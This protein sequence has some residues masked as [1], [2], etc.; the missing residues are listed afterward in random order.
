MGAG[1]IGLVSM[2]AL[3]A[4]GVSEVYVVDVMDK[5]LEKAME[6]GATGVI[7]G[8]KEDV[9]AKVKELTGGRGTDVVIETAGAEVTSS[10]LLYTS[11]QP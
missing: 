7:N 3:K 10:C 9:V 8:A 5:R 2:M 4:R 6:L 11:V 1:C